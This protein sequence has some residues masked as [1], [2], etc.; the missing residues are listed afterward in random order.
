[1][2]HVILSI[3]GIFLIY[4][5]Y[6]KI[7]KYKDVKRHATVHNYLWRQQKPITME[8]TWMLR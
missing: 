8:K 3:S 7:L 4:L 2:H 1:M 6:A 5:G